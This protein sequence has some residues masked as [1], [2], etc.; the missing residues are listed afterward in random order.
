[1][2]SYVENKIYECLRFGKK[3]RHVYVRVSWLFAKKNGGKYI[4]TCA[5]MTSW[6]SKY[7]LV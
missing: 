5:K 6:V 2:L 7:L 1:M 4:F 3:V